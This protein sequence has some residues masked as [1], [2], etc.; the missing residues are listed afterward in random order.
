M[1]PQAISNILLVEKKHFIS[2]S[3]SFT[4]L[5][6]PVRQPA[7]AQ[8]PAALN[9]IMCSMLTL[10]F[11]RWRACSKPWICSGSIFSKKTVCVSYGQGIIVGRIDALCSPK[12]APYAVHAFHENDL[13]V[14]LWPIEI[15]DWSLEVKY[16]LIWWEQWVWLIH[17][18]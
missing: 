1:S 9:W 4:S 13:K 17:F 12:I 6:I 15:I 14:G 10:S 2:F 3:I 11:F 8:F 7:L 5:E 16:C 18:K